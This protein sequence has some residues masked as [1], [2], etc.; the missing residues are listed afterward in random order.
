[1]S[2]EADRPR[3]RRRPHLTTRVLLTCAVFAAV[4]VLLYVT[5]APFTAALAAIFP[6]AYAVLAGTYSVMTFAARLFVGQ[7]GAATLTAML[8]GVL[9]AVA[10]PIGFFVLVPL[11]VAAAAFDLVLLVLGS[12]RRLSSSMLRVVA[13]VFSAIALFAV[14]LPVL[15]AEHLV[16]GMLAFTLVGRIVGQLAAVLCA[17]GVVGLLIRAGVRPP[18]TAPLIR[19]A[20]P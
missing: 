15:S 4:Q 14:S 6:P 11:T 8:T 18:P 2:V 16:F 12:R 7:H 3:F 5:I 10:S 20:G 9:V 13:A 17:V 1:M 19:R